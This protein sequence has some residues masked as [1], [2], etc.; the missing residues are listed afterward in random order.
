MPVTEPVPAP[1]LMLA[2]FKGALEFARAVGV[3][4]EQ[5]DVDVEGDQ[6]GLVLGGEDV[7][8]ELGAGVLLHGEDVLLAAAGVEQ[9]ADGEGQVLFLGEVLGLLRLLVLED[10]AV[11]LVQVGDEAVLVADGEVDVHQVDV[12]LQGL[13]VADIDWLLAGGGAGWR[14]ATGRGGFLGAQARSEGETETGA[15]Q[16]R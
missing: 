3:V 4:G 9:N 5:I 2:L 15:E 12:D 13:D 16:G 1:V 8:E 10:L 11:V 7:F 14:G 6:E